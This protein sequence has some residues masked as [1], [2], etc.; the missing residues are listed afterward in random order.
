MVNYSPSEAQTLF[1][2]IEALRRPYVCLASNGD[3]FL[4]KK[5]EV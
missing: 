2:S 1:E 3:S 4:Y 5:Q